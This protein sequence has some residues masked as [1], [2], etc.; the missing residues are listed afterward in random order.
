MQERTITL[1]LITTP[2]PPG[3]HG[4]SAKD[5]GGDD[6]YIVLLNEDDDPD[7]QQEAFIHELLHIWHKDHDRQGADVQQLEAER[8][9]ETRREIERQQAGEAG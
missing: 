4:M 5:K 6:N 2:L 8:H 3:A 9:A 1:R 7:A